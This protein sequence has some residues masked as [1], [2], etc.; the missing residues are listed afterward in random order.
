[1]LMNRMIEEKI[2]KYEFMKKKIKYSL[3][4]VNKKR[5]IHSLISTQSKAGGG[6]SFSM[7]GWKIP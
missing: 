2:S 1:M 5:N 3:R 4:Q 6:A 7:I